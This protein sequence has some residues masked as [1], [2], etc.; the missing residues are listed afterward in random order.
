M[1]ATCVLVDF[2]VNAGGQQ[3]GNWSNVKKADSI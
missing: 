3:A 2:E 1:S